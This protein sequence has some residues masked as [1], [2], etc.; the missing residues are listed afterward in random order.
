MNYILLSY[1]ILITFILL[2]ISKDIT[3]FGRGIQPDKNGKLTMT[4]Q[5]KMILATSKLK[6]FFWPSKVHL[7]KNSRGQLR[8]I[9]V[10]LINI[11]SKLLKSKDEF[12][13]VILSLISNLGCIVLAYFIL[14]IYFSKNVAFFGAALYATSIWPYQVALFFGHILLA[15]FFFFLSIF[16]LALTSIYPEYTYLLIFISGFLSIICF[17]S[18][19]AS[20]KYPPIIFAFFIFTLYPNIDFIINNNRGLIL[21]SLILANIIIFQIIK[22]KFY[23]FIKKKIEQNVTKDSV[24]TYFSDFKKKLIKLYHIPALII[25][26]FFCYNKNIDVLFK[27]SIF[28]LGII[29]ASLII[30]YPNF[31]R[32]IGRYFVFLEIGN[33]ANHFRSY[34]KNYFKQDTSGNFRAPATYYLNFLPRFCP[35]ILLLYISSFLIILFSNYFLFKE[36]LLY[37]FLSLIPLL[38]IE[39]SKAMRVSKSYLPILIGLIFLIIV[40]AAKL[41]NNFSDNIFFLSIIILILFNLLHKIFFLVKDVIPTRLGPSNLAKFLIKN[42]I[43]K[44]GTYNNPY[45]DEIVG[46]INQKFPKKINFQFYETIDE[47]KNCDYFLI[48][49]RCAKSITMETQQF[50]IKNGD[51]KMDKKLNEIEKNGILEIITF[52]KFKTLGTSRFFVGE[53]EISGFREFC[54]KDISDADRK[55]TYALILDLRKLKNINEK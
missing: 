44:I 15:Q 16:T 28:V 17:S 49:Q 35:V 13:N 34:P 31:I 14:D 36:K 30:L 42:K 18:S 6:L 55:I 22:N 45:N 4:D 51:F 7:I 20:R 46:P 29:L 11:F 47:C 5:E 54:L 12:L 26:I 21:I 25:L 8:E 19:S 10:I 32:G 1:S 40:V 23:G 37:I 24:E 48:P 27:F 2:F 52:K 39:L 41:E 3:Y 53:S 9:W 38:I 50:A 33:W 43:Y